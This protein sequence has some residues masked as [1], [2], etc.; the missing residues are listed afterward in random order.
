MVGATFCNNK[1][2]CNFYIDKF[3]YDD[4]VDD[5]GVC[6]CSE[7]PVSPTKKEFTIIRD[8]NGLIVHVQRILRL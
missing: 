2:A 7:T 8:F 4:I 6:V 1:F 3:I 5:I